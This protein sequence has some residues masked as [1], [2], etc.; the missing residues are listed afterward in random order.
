MA[1]ERSV[2]LVTGATGFL[3]AA[4]VDELLSQGDVVRCVVRGATEAER[5]A[6]LRAGLDG[7]AAEGRSRVEAVPGDLSEEFLGLSAGDFAALGEGVHR[8]VHCGARVNM[9]LPYG[10]LYEAN[11]RSTEYLLQLAEGRRARFNYVG[12]LAAVARTVTGEP[13]ELTEPVSGGYAMSKW[14]A[15]RLVSVAHQEGRV[16]AA[17]FRPGRITAGLALPRSNPDDLL[18]SVVR[19]CVLLGRAPVLET[20]VRFSPVDWVGRLVVALSGTD[21][22]RGRAYH[23]IHAET[24]AWADVVRALDRAGYAL[25]EVPYPSWRAM[26]IDAGRH[27][28]DVARVAS[29]LP[30]EELS[31]DDRLTAR[32]R[33]ARRTMA[34]AYPEL[35]PAETLAEQTLAA[36]QKTGLLPAV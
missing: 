21:G 28:T 17:I 20:S 22:S 36:W 8:V 23:L 16:D 30:A 15:D 14:S 27:D 6:K 34:D 1:G 12:S 24:V 26:A 5:V 10:S 29:A 31:F 32:P 25:A 4:L 9:T 3:G 7:L 2:S 33:H 19:I 11:V 18:E 35:P 13:F